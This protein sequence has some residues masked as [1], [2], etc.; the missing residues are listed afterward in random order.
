MS[1]ESYFFDQGD[2]Q[3]KVSML[4]YFGKVYDTKITQTR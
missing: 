4:N 1:P 3:Q 2:A